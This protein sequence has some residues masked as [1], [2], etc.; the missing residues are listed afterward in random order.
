MVQRSIVEV[1]H[2]G[3]P[4]H[5][6]QHVR[7]VVLLAVMP[8]IRFETVHIRVVQS[9]KVSSFLQDSFIDQPTNSY[10]FSFRVSLKT[11]TY[12]LEKPLI[13]GMEE[14]AASGITVSGRALGPLWHQTYAC[15]HF[16]RIKLEVLEHIEVVH[17]IRLSLLEKSLLEQIPN[18]EELVTDAFLVTWRPAIRQL[19]SL[20]SAILPR[21]V[22]RKDQVIRVPKQIDVV[23]Y[24]DVGKL[25][26]RCSAQAV[27]AEVPNLVTAPPD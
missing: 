19:L 17:P 25:F 9:I 21:E 20:Q 7:I 18:H 5:L 3:W 23:V 8:D 15:R 13:L 27:G 6:I 26:S 11:I 24:L 14:H 16:G 1:N 2:L 4:L 12:G 10:L 22:G